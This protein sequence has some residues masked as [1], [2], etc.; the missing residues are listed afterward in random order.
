MNSINKDNLYSILTFLDI[1]DLIRISKI[2]K[3]TNQNVKN[4]KK[5]ILKSKLIR[6]WGR[7]IYN[8]LPE[9]NIQNFTKK[10]L[11][12]FLKILEIFYQKVLINNIPTKSRL[13]IEIYDC[14]YS[15]T[16]RYDYSRIDLFKHRT[17]SIRKILNNKYI[18][19][20]DKKVHFILNATSYLNRYCHFLNNRIIGIDNIEAIKYINC[21]LEYDYVNDY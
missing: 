15:F 2:D 5:L 14:I 11:E 12:T 13:L 8:L 3:F 6:L 9:D 16:N 1:D 21:E 4:N 10:N 20:N 7:N 18:N 19:H 17:D